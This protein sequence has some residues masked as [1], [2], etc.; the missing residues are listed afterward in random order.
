MQA[1]VLSMANSEHG[2]WC[3]GAPGPSMFEGHQTRLIHVT[4]LM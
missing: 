2:V 1:G 3:V 4:S